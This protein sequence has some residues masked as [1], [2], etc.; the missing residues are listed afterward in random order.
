MY[1]TMEQIEREYDG[2]WVFMVNCDKSRGSL[3]GGEVVLHDPIKANVL[4]AMEA[5]DHYPN[6]TSFRYVGKIP[7]GIVYVL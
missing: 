7:E 3:V 2:N 1:K 4:L 5:Y 6:L